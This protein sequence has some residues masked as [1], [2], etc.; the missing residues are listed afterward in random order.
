MLLRRFR[1]LYRIRGKATSPVRLMGGR[2]LSGS[3]LSILRGPLRIQ[4]FGILTKMA[5]VFMLPTLATFRFMATGFG[6]AFGTSA[7]LFIG[8][9]PPVGHVCSVVRG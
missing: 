9:L 2:P 5:F 8:Q 6:L 1:R 3:R 7:I 4:T